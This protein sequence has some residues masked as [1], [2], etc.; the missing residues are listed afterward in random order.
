VKLIV[1]HTAKEPRAP[2]VVTALSK[3]MAELVP[4]R[5]AAGDDVLILLLF[6]ISMSEF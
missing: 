1:A 2:A 6:Q 3:E 4:E 5:P